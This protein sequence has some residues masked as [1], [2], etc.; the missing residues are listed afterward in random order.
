MVEG[1][2]RRTGEVLWSFYDDAAA[3]W[4]EQTSVRRTRS[5]LGRDWAF[6]S[7]WV[8]AFASGSAVRLG[9]FARFRGDPWLIV[10]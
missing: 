7:V 4:A 3:G 6:I 1:S 8:A 9:A 10:V 5:K 2:P